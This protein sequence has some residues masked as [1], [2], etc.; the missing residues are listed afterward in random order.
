M[1]QATEQP[2]IIPE[3]A[4]QTMFRVQSTALCR[5]L[6]EKKARRYIKA[7]TDMLIDEATRSNVAPIRGEMSKAANRESAQGA[8]AWFRAELPHL[9]EVIGGH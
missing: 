5:A 9:W 7:M 1:P 6:G 8:V 3:V 2:T 4:W